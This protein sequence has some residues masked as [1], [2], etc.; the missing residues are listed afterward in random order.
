MTLIYIALFV[1]AV[2]MLSAY[3]QSGS[4]FRNWLTSA[5][6]G[7]GGLLLGYGAGLLGLPL[8][9]LGPASALIAGFLGLPGVIGLM[10]AQLMLKA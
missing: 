5:V 7:L 3:W 8:I 4:F 9:T 10:L 6:T 2:V 1:S